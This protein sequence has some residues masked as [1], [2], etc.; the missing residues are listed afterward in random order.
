MSERR[1]ELVNKLFE[2][3]TELVTSPEKMKEFAEKWRGG[4]HSYSFQ[5]LMLI[6]VQYPK[7]T[8]CAGMKQ[9]NK[10]RRYVKKGSKGLWILAPVIRKE[11]VIEVDEETGEETERIVEKFSYRF[12]PVY[13]FDISQTDGEKLNIG[14]TAVNGNGV[15]TVQQLKEIFPDY[16][17]IISNGLADGST[18]G[19]Y[20][21]VS[22]RKSSEQMTCAYLH[23]LAHILLGHTG[24]RGKKLDKQIVEIE[25]ES[26]AYL[27]SSCLGIENEG[28]KYYVSHWGGSKDNLKKSSL[29]II[30][31]AERILR[32]IKPE[33]FK[34]PLPPPPEDTQRQ[35]SFAN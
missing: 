15:V 24:E 30:S 16:D 9:W 25:A 5:N 3:S 27:V 20:I 23:E 28:A 26:C 21:K 18:N 1:K 6:W 14:N 19:E 34:S 13:V 4:F 35:F 31:T 12:F 29:K 11:K 17:L 7:A 32:K 10:H 2:L 33:R 8:I 22:E